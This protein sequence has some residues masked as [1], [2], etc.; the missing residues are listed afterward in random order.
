MKRNKY[1]KYI[2]VVLLYRNLEDVLNFLE[3]VRKTMNDYHVIL[4]DSFF[5]NKTN[6]RAK[7][8]AE[9]TP[10][11]SF[12]T[13]ENRGYGAGNNAGIAYART[14]F[15]YDYIIISNP[16]VVI[17][18]FDEQVLL[19]SSEEALYAPKIISRDHKRQN[20]NW[21]MHSN[22]LEYFQYLACKKD[23]ILLDYTV[24]AILKIMRI[25]LGNISD[26]FHVKRFSIGNAHGSFFILSQA[27]VE[28]LHPLF[29]ENMFLF[30]EEVYL[31]NKAYQKHVP[32]YYTPSIL[33]YHK[34]DGSMRIA[35]LNTRKEAH[36]SVVY[37]YEHKDCI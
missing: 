29:D 15:S 18:H 32:I 31:G 23:N 2:F 12:L 36:K 27:A 30:Y 26:I 28:R 13:V 11:C 14:N 33:V 35:N 8:I 34:E 7:Q 3:S 22:V 25:V 5:D 6:D 20:P 21:A 16:D 9:S 1:Y 19:D 17:D 37:Y 24:I 10:S 4:V